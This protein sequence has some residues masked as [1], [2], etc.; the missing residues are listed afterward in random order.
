MPWTRTHEII[1]SSI[2]LRRD[3]TLIE[4]KALAPT[5]DHMS[6]LE[7]LEVLKNI[8]AQHDYYISTGRNVFQLAAQML[9]SGRGQRFYR[10]EWQEGTCDK[11]VTL[12]AIR[13]DR[14]GL[15]GVAYGYTT[16]HGET[17]LIPVQIQYADTPG[18]Y[19]DYSM[20]RAVPP[21]EI[22]NPPPSI[23]TEVPVDPKTY[24]LKAYPFYDAPNPPEF[25]ERLLKARG[26]LPDAPSA[27]ETPSQPTNENVNAAT[28]DGSVPHIPK[29]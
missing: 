15:T 26:M 18:W 2:L 16:F 23:G 22:V 4:G 5:S 20:E 11:Y 25:V 1:P 29:I 13:F 14:D 17:T 27:A 7:P 3:K 6:Q 12:T 24:K 10:K 19:V 28:S 9:Y 8:V 21:T